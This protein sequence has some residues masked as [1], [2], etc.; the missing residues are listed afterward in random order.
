[1]SHSIQT[2]AVQCHSHA[3]RSTIGSKFMDMIAIGRQRKALSQL[4]AHLL[5][6]IGVSAREASIESKKPLWDAPQYW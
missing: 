2:T 5:E 6:D 4:D 3:K 1:M